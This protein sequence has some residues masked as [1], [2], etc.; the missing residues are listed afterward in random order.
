MSPQR[1][2]TLWSSTVVPPAVLLAGCAASGATRR[3]QQEATL[4][5]S[6]SKTCS[7]VSVPLV[8]APTE[9]IP[10]IPSPGTLVLQLSLYTTTYRRFRGKS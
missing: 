4:A 7:S 3:A 2:Q 6:L 5:A 10:Y 8:A 1:L 9:H